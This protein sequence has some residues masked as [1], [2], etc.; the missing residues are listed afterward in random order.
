MWD[1]NFLWPR[2]VLYPPYRK[3]KFCG[4]SSRSIAK[5]RRGKHWAKGPINVGTPFSYFHLMT[6]TTSF[7]K[8]FIDKQPRQWA[9]SKTVEMQHTIVRTLRQNL[10]F[11]CEQECFLIDTFINILA[12]KHLCNSYF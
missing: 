8:L 6:E 5:V 3:A 11:T 1:P 7:R 4:V 9:M 10:Q 2:I 12:A